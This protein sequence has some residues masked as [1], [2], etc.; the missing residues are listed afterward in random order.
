M[1]VRGR[2]ERDSVI[3][4]HITACVRAFIRIAVRRPG[5]HREPCVELKGEGPSMMT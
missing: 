5:A 2:S 4:W 1:G 3:Q